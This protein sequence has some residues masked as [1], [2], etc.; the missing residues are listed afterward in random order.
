MVGTCPKCEKRFRLLWR[1]GGRK[2]DKQQRLR[3]ACPS[4]GAAFEEVCVKLST[5]STG[6]ESFPTT[7]AV[8]V[9][10]LIGSVKPA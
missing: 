7:F 4:C 2:L 5:F 9:D 8:T 6:K 1:I 3:L 10:C